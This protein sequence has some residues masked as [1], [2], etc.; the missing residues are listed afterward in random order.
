LIQL[1]HRGAEG[2]LQRKSLCSPEVAI[3]M[4]LLSRGDK[5]GGIAGSVGPSIA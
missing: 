4:A 2:D 5:A 1:L 3:I